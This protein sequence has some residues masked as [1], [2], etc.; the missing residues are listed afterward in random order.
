MSSSQGLSKD[1]YTDEALSDVT[2]QLRPSGLH[3]SISTYATMR[4][5][6]D[7]LRQGPYGG[8]LIVVHKR[9][10]DALTDAH[11]GSVARQVTRLASPE[12]SFEVARGARKASQRVLAAAGW[13]V[14]LF[15]AAG[16]AT[17]AGHATTAAGYVAGGLLLSAI[18]ASFQH[19][20]RARTAAHQAQELKAEVGAVALLK[21]AGPV[22]ASLEADRERPV[23][24][25]A[26]LLRGLRSALGVEVDPAPE[27]REQVVKAVAVGMRAAADVARGAEPQPPVAPE[28]PVQPQLPA[29]LVRG[30]VRPPA[31]VVVTPPARPAATAGPVTERATRPTAG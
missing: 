18:T 9:P 17:V 16:A 20:G 5:V 12:W 19:F 7:S 15:A 22:L 11:R 23:S 31:S 13:T 10:D 27:M 2:A 26:R 28:S 30:S 21:N 14:F 6:A 25:S 1:L 8:A 24:L 3:R 4:D 29:R